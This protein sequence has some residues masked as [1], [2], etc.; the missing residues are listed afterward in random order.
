M[1]VY[2]RFA[3]LLKSNV[4]QR[5]CFSSL[6]AAPPPPHPHPTTSTPLSEKSFCPCVIFYVQKTNFLIYQKL[7]SLKCKQFNCLCFFLLS[8]SLLTEITTDQHRP[9]FWSVKCLRVLSTIIACG[10]RSKLHYTPPTPPPPN[11]QSPRKAQGHVALTT[12]SYECTDA[13]EDRCFR[14]MKP[15]LPAVC[16]I[17]AGVTSLGPSS[18]ALVHQLHNSRHRKASD[19][20]LYLQFVGRIK[21]R[22][23]WTCSSYVRRHGESAR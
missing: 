22:I 5:S 9:L 14:V 1:R 2:R 4:H 8:L 7:F 16:S 13:G 21:G 12:A 18:L 17:Q 11:P 19:L 6:D 3:V 20:S 15:R 23:N 10:I